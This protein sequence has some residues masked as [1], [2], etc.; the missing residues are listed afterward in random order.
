[1]EST[2]YTDLPDEE[3]EIASTETSHQVVCLL[4]LVTAPDEWCIASLLDLRKS[5]KSVDSS[6]DK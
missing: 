2:D 1:M 6:F 3:E 5:A 4:S